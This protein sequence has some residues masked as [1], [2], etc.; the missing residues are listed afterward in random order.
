MK[1]IA[2]VFVVALGFV[3]SFQ[4]ALAEER[5]SGDPTGGAPGSVSNSE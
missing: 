3:L 5:G 4:P 1:R 2:W